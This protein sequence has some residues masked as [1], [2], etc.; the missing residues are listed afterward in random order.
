MQ[1]QGQILQLNKV[2]Q[3]YDQLKRKY[4]LKGKPTTT[5]L[6]ATIYGETTKKISCYSFQQRDIRNLG[7]ISHGRNSTSPP[8]PTFI[9]SWNIVFHLV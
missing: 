4:I 1:A 6:P 9:P 3:Q 7:H 8:I 2:P 5:I